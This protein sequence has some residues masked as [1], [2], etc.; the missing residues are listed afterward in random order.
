MRYFKAGF[1]TLLLAIDKVAPVNSMRASRGDQ[2]IAAFSTLRAPK[3]ARTEGNRSLSAVESSIIN[4]T[5]LVQ[6]ALL[7]WLFLGETLSAQQIAGMLLVG[8]A[9]V[10]VSVRPFTQTED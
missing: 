3:S 5:M 9:I 8:V 10:A 4:S 1:I 7:A 2:A 6:I